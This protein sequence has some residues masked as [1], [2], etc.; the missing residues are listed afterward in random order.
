MSPFETE[1]DPDGVLPKAERDRRA[2]AARRAY[3]T[4]LAIASAQARRKAS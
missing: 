1:V 2:A 3:F 4:K